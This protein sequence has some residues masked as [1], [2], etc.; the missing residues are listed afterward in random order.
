MYTLLSVANYLD[1]LEEI[2]VNP[3]TEYFD[4]IRVSELTN[5]FQDA[6]NTSSRWLEKEEESFFTQMSNHFSSL[7]KRA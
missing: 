7:I 3:A 5:L 4:D 6:I 1:E 2:V